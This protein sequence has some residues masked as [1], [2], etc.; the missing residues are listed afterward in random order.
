V[1]AVRFEGVHARVPGAGIAV[2]ALD[3]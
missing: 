3:G 2:E 1:S